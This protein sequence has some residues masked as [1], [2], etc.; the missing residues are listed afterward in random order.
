MTTGSPGPSLLL[1]FIKLWDERTNSDSCGGIS[2]INNIYLTCLEVGFTS[3]KDQLMCHKLLFFKVESV[4]LELRSPQSSSCPFCVCTYKI[5]H[6]LC[7]WEQILLQL[8]SCQSSQPLL[9]VAMAIDV[10]QFG[11]CSTQIGLFISSF[12]SLLPEWLTRPSKK[13]LV[14]VNMVTILHIF[15]IP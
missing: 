8:I 14:L 4:I 1:W 15:F 13:C 2:V 12:N 9:V 5:W 11:G 10:H 7:K 3:I 6:W